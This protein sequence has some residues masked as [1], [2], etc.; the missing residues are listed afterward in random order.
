MA[1]AAEAAAAP[2]LWA[3]LICRH[4]IEVESTAQGDAPAR[5]QSSIHQRRIGDV[6]IA[7]IEAHGQCV[8]RTKAVL[9]RDNR[10]HF[11]LSIQRS[12]T[13]V[14]RQD[15]REALLR[16]GEMAFCSS[17]RCYEL[18]FDASFEQTVIIFPADVVCAIRPGVEA[19]AGLTLDVGNP[20][21]RV[22]RETA[23]RFFETAFERRGA[24]SK[25]HA[26]EKLCHLFAAA[27]AESGFALDAHPMASPMMLERR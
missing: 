25:E 3:D 16:K 23:D 18:A 7:H 14:L 27:L 11:L 12:G 24:V 22:L 4:L 17:K 15:G 8:I 6:D 19:L 26:A 9:A 10:E 21:L 2:P 5:F 1:P 13:G 20:L